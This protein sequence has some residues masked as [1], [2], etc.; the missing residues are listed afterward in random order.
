MAGTA[1][2]KSG[3]AALPEGDHFLIDNMGFLED[4]GVVDRAFLSAY[5]GGFSAS[6]IGKRG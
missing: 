4:K 5:T 3:P 1:D 6:R 2:F